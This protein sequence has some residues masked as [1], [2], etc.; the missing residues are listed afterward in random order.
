MAF[1]LCHAPARQTRSG[2]GVTW[3]VRVPLGLATVMEVAVVSSVTVTFLPV[4]FASSI[5][6]AFEPLA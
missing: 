3:V 4:R 1:A 6:Q 5:A 2:P